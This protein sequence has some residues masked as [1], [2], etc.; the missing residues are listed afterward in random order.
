MT[1]PGLQTPT[2]RRLRLATAWLAGCSGCHM[3]LLDLHLELLELA[4][5]AEVVASPVLSDVKSYPDEVDLCLVEGAVASEDQRQ[6]AL[7]IRARTSKVVALGDCAIHTNI[8]GL[9][10]RWPGW[11][12]GTGSV[13]ATRDRSAADLVDPPLPTPLAVVLPLE[14]VIAV[15]AYLPG[16][17]PRAEAIAALLRRWWQGEGLSLPGCPPQRFG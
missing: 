17:P 15:D 4:S 6:Q 1:S 12:A 11:S 10:H 16:C 8:T 9:R 14:A 2:R 5:Q 7:L 13:V 3:A